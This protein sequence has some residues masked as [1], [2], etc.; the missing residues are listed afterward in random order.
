MHVFADTGFL[1]ISTVFHR[2]IISG[3]FASE[4]HSEFLDQLKC[5]FT[6]HNNC[7]NLLIIISSDYWDEIIVYLGP[8]SAFSNQVQ[9]TMML[10]NLSNVLPNLL[11]S[12]L[13]LSVP[14]MEEI[15]INTRY[16]SHMPPGRGGKSTKSLT[17]QFSEGLRRLSLLIATKPNCSQGNLAHCH[18][19]TE[20]FVGACEQNKN[21]FAFS[22]HLPLIAAL[23]NKLTF[24]LKLQ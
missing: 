13:N 4:F 17:Y 20:L 15:V 16:I 10:A 3:L 5:M 12:C 18:F 23:G 2:E 6:F 22:A 1:P 8:V 19:P 21:V 24:F 14:Q 11:I 9:Q 7:M